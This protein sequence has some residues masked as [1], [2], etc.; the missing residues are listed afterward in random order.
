MNDEFIEMVKRHA[1]SQEK[2]EADTAKYLEARRKW[3]VE[4]VD[5]LLG[6]IERWLR[7]L[8]NEQT[9]TFTKQ[10]LT[11][12]EDHLGTYPVN[13]AEIRLADETLQL[14]PIGSLILGSFGRI[15]LTGPNGQVMLILNAEKASAQTGYRPTNP[16]WYI[17]KKE[18]NG[19]FQKELTEATFEEVFA[20]LFGIDR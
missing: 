20:D 16:T 4:E 1:S 6:E 15:D 7:P 17:V 9:I 18:A 3:W 10:H 11:I 13:S 8:L 14:K 19:R 12:T 2:Q 5:K